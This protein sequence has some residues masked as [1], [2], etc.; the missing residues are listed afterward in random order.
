[1][2]EE[3]GMKFRLLEQ[4]AD[5]KDFLVSSPRGFETLQEGRIHDTPGIPPRQREEPPRF[6]LEGIPHRN[7][8]RPDGQRRKTNLWPTQP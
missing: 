5:A 1:M 3:E 2:R 8:L 7:T 4:H 6:A